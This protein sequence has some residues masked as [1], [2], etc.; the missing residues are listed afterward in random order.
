MGPTRFVLAAKVAPIELPGAPPASASRRVLVSEAWNT[1]PHLEAGLE[2]AISLAKAG[3]TVDYLHYGNQVTKVGYYNSNWEGVRSKLV[4]YS[5]S[6]EQSGIET[7]RRASKKL[8]L[9]IAFLKAKGLISENYS[10]IA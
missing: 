8:G 2:I 9:D 6:P 1:S 7:L 3:Y 10:D 4:G 5:S